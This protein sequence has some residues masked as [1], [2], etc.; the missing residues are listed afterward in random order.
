MPVRTTGQ[1]EIVKAPIKD[2]TSPLAVTDRC[3]RFNQPAG[4]SF[5]F[6]LYETKRTCVNYDKITNVCFVRPVA[7]EM[8]NSA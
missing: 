4:G 6:F 5:F 2:L 1:Q 7:R 8:A 3:Q